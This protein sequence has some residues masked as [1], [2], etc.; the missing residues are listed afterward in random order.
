MKR[1][2]I[3]N[4]WHFLSVFFTISQFSTSVD[5][6]AF[7]FEYADNTRKGWIGLGEG[8]LTSLSNDTAL[9]SRVLF[10]D[11]DSRTLLL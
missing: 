10:D 6:N 9:R 4:E 7:T 3:A 5:S 8:V 2:F 1:L 11:N